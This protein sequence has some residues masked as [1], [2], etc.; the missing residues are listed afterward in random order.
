[1]SEYSIHDNIV[2]SDNTL[3]KA[4]HKVIPIFLTG[5]A[6]CL[7]SRIGESN[8]RIEAAEAWI[9]TE[10]E[11]SGVAAW[12][13]EAEVGASGDMPPARNKHFEWE[14]KR[15][16]SNTFFIVKIK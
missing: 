6:R 8:P 2:A 15:S 4:L 3:Y 5:K 12:K 14:S 10:S 7:N 9:R 13:H 16:K 11:S 1:M